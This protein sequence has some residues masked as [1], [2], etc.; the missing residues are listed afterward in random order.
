[1]RDFRCIQFE[2]SSDFCCFSRRKSLSFS[3]RSHSNTHNDVVSIHDWA[4][5]FGEVAEYNSDF[6]VRNRLDLSMTQDMGTMGWCNEKIPESSK[7][8]TQNVRIMSLPAPNLLRHLHEFTRCVNNICTHA[9]FP[10]SNCSVDISRAEQWKEWRESDGKKYE[11]M[12]W[13]GK[14]LSFKSISAIFSRHSITSVNK[15]F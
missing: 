4:K 1:M 10:R 5:C 9:P 2:H 3:Q 15:A 8:P 12:K 11:K 14:I 7:Y 13:D 6:K